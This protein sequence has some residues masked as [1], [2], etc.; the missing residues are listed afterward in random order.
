MN[1]T[2]ASYWAG[3]LDGEGSIVIS[4]SAKGQ[5]SLH[6]THFLRVLIY[7]TDKALIESAKTDFG[8]G[9]ITKT[10]THHP[11]INGRKNTKTSTVYAFNAITN[12]AEQFLK[13]IYPYLRLKKPQADL[14]FKFQEYKRQTTIHGRKKGGEY[15]KMS[16]EVFDNRE[17]FKIELSKLNNKNGAK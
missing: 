3:M 8:F 13:I 10:I 5:R 12:N 17:Q 14:A 7:N 11:V 4:K 2:T 15:P 16:Q 1:Q 9:C 6:L